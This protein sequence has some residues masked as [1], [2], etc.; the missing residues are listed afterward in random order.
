[1]DFLSF[2]FKISI[3]YKLLICFLSFRWCKIFP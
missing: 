1:M 2:F 3:L